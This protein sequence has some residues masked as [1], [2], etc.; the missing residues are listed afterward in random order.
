MVQFLVSIFKSCHNFTDGP[1][2]TCQIKSPMSRGRGLAPR[3]PCA[4]TGFL[5]PTL[6][7]S[8][9]R[10][11]TSRWVLGTRCHVLCPF[12]RALVASWS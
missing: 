6:G 12:D 7:L 9:L 8:G 2:N 1:E 4:C 5:L 10:E 3:G 11:I